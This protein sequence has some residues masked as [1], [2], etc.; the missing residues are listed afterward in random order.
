MDKITYP[1]KKTRIPTSDPDYQV[2][3]DNMNQIKSVVNSAVD[4]VDSNTSKLS[5][6]ESG[7]QVNVQSDW[8]E[9]NTSSKQY[10]LNKEYA[11][12]LTDATTGDLYQLVVDN[13]E[14]KVEAV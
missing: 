8:L 3:A 9:T 10:I 12:I 6:I 14:F 7:A 5:G 4:Q 1:N 2:S 11:L 13:G